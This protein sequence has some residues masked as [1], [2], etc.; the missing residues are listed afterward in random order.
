[1]LIGVP[2]EIK[3][4]ES[5]V[6]LVPNS[7]AELTGRGHSVLVET[8]AGAGIG[9]GDDAYRAVGAEIAAMIMETDAFNYYIPLGITQIVSL[10]ALDNIVSILLN[11]SYDCRHPLTDAAKAIAYFYRQAN[12]HVIFIRW[13]FFLLHSCTGAD[14]VTRYIFHSLI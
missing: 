6:G 4:R 7:V 13:L 11:T 8:G 12:L 2:K 1:M 14:A 5:R 3:V 10:R 9:A